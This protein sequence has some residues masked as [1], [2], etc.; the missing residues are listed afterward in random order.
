MKVLDLSRQDRAE[1][2]AMIERY[3]MT[4]GRFDWKEEDMAKLQH[5]V[6]AVLDIKP[7]QLKQLL[8]PDQLGELVRE[9]T[10]DLKVKE[11]RE[12]CLV[13]TLPGGGNG[14]AT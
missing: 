7:E 5:L 10:R 2:D 14:N 12:T 1:L 6:S 4:G 3:V 9:K 8:S 13:L 11:V